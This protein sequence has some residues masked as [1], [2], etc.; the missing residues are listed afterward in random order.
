MIAEPTSSEAVST[1]V[2][3]VEPELTHVLDA[4]MYFSVFG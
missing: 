3:G 1:R 2:T 4:G